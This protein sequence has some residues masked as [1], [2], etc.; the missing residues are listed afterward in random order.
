MAFHNVGAFVNGTRPKS[1]KALREAIAT[2]QTVH[3]DGTSAFE[4]F[5]LYDPLELAEGERLSVVGPDPYNKRSWYATIERKANG[6]IVV[7]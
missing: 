6:R 1:K 7:S 3:F 4:S 5:Y 2:G